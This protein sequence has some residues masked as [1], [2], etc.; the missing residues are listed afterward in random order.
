MITLS[1]ISALEFYRHLPQLTVH[2]SMRRSCQDLASFSL[3]N[4]PQV[5]IN[6][7]SRSNGKMQPTKKELVLFLARYGQY[8][9]RPIHIMVSDSTHRL[10]H[11]SVINHVCTKVDLE[12]I[13]LAIEP[14]LA[15][16]R[17]EICFIQLAA[18]LPDTQAITVGAELCGTYRINNFTERGYICTQPLTSQHAMS[19][20]LQRQLPLSGVKRARQLVKYVHDNSR[21]P[22]ESA[23]ATILTLPLKRGGQAFPAMQLNGALPVPTDAY[24]LVRSR[25]LFADLL[26]E[27]QQVIVEY[28]GILDHTGAEKISQDAGRRIALESMGFTVLTLTK[29]Q[30][31]SWPSFLSVV[32]LLDKHLGIRRRPSKH[33]W[34]QLQHQVWSS[35]LF[36]R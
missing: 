9:S 33:D 10:Q 11:Q 7:S 35:L 3:S 31:Y 1:D 32:S 16:V 6:P 4:T 24:P 21:S 8:F 20:T 26:W 30:V 5:G 17:P 2:E 19:K 23:L 13:S 36:Q 22:M 27:E 28:D 25:C 18:S 12:S 29:K 15:V 14:H 34:S